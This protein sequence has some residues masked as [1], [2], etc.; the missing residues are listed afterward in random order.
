MRFVDTLATASRGLRQAAL[1]EI[2]SD[3]DDTCYLVLSDV[4]LDQPRVCM[5]NHAATENEPV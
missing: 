2:E 4:W 3:A 5:R 1:R